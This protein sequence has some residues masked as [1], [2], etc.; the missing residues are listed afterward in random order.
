M[1]TAT[2]GQQMFIHRKRGAQD[3]EF[4]GQFLTFSVFK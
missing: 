4:Y 3:T 1:V 2:F